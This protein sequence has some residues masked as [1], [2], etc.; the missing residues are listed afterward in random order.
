MKKTLSLLTLAAVMTI[1]C[2]WLGNT[3]VLNECDKCGKCPTGCCLEGVC[4][5]ADCACVCKAD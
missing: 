1:G 4:D 3:P 2:D 5:N